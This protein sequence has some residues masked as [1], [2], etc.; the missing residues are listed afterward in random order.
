M[1]FLYT[2]LG[3]IGAIL[4]C[5]AVFLFGMFI[6]KWINDGVASCCIAFVVLIFTGV[7]IVAVIENPVKVLSIIGGITIPIASVVGF[8]FRKNIKLPKIPNLLSK[9]T[10]F[11]ISRRTPRVLTPPVKIGEPVKRSIYEV[12]NEA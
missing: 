5:G 11:S 7:L 3:T 4:F 1:I 9:V 12:I 2:I 10:S 6:D 8:I